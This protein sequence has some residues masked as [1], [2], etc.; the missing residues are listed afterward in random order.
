[1]AAACWRKAY[2]LMEYNIPDIAGDH[3]GKI[4]EICNNL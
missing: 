1:M 3:S 2:I 4:S